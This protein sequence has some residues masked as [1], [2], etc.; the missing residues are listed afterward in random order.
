[1]AKPAVSALSMTLPAIGT[2]F[3]QIG[4]T[5]AYKRGSFASGGASP[6]KGT[7]TGPLKGLARH[8]VLPATHQSQTCLYFQALSYHHIRHHYP[9]LLIERTGS[10][11]SGPFT[12]S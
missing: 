7:I 1:M 11:A 9:H 3:T 4:G 5:F 10:C 12:P 2:L 8:F 6:G